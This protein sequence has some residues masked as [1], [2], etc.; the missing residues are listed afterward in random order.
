MGA[1]E[2]KNFVK[3]RLQRP[4][5]QHSPWQ[6]GRALRVGLHT[7]RETGAAGGIAGQGLRLGGRREAL[8]K[9][10]G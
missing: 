7:G 9:E 6:P 4:A 3:F 10:R 5:G 2:E 1:E 8:I